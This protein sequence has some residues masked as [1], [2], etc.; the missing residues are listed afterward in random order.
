MIQSENRMRDHE[1]H[2]DSRSLMDLI[3]DLRD[4]TVTLLRQ[5]VTLA[6]TETTEK[7]SVAGRN[8]AFL[9]T[10]GLIAYAG[11]MF[12]LL[13]AVVALYVALVAA[14]G[15]HATSG[16]LSPLIIGGV[17]TAI[18]AV[19]V[20]KALHTFRNESFD[21]ERTKASVTADKEWI[22]EKVT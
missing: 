11:L 14:G 8:A 2:R 7:V 4:E 10:G 16:W 3:K 22:Q 6:K 12:V 13:A 5:E 19:L 15:S 1:L 18:G 9:C 17:V 21:L 20:Q